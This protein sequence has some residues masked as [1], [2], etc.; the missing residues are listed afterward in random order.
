MTTGAFSEKNTN[1]TV[2]K[3]PPIYFPLLAPTPE[4][5]PVFAPKKNA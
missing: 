1:I 3:N 4:T 2:F 5:E